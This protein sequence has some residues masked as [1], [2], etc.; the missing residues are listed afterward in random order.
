MDGESIVE[1][2]F[3]LLGTGFL[4]VAA[5]W[6]ARF[7]TIT[8]RE[9]GPSSDAWRGH[10]KV[11]LLCLIVPGVVAL[12]AYDVG[13]NEILQRYDL[14]ELEEQSEK[15]LQVVQQKAK[16]HGIYYAVVVGLVLIIPAWYGVSRGYKIS[17]RVLPLLTQAFSASVS[18]NKVIPTLAATTIA[19]DTIIAGRYM[20]CDHEGT[21]VSSLYVSEHG[22]VLEIGESH[23]KQTRVLLGMTRA[24]ASLHLCNENGDSRVMLSNEGHHS[25]IS[26]LD[27]NGVRASVSLNESRDGDSSVVMIQCLGT[28]GAKILCSMV[29][30]YPTAMITDHTGKILWRVNL[31][32]N[33]THVPTSSEMRDLASQWAEEEQSR[34][35]NDSPTDAS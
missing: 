32:D 9:K 3:K 16:D 7:Y 33:E 2:I 19:A 15:L 30:D 24:G 26:M 18:P 31:P 27:K 8:Y 13:R 20:L 1:G 4:I 12:F 10:L 11:Y 17:R 34:Q 22:P 35:V 5:Y 21:P 28:D 23:H 29:G 6:V 14:S 25:S